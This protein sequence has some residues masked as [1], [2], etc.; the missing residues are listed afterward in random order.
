MR[1]SDLWGD[2]ELAPAIG[3]FLAEVDA[4]YPHR[5]MRSSG[6]IADSHHD[7]TSGH[8]PDAERLVVAADVDKDGVDM[9]QLVNAFIRH[10]AAHY[11]I[12]HRVIWSRSVGFAPSAFH[13]DNPHDDHGH[14]QVL[15]GAPAHLLTPYGIHTAVDHPARP[16]V[17]PGLRTLWY[18]RPPFVG[19]DVRYVQRFIGEAKCGHADGVFGP[20]TERGVRWY[21]GM[22][23]LRVDGIVGPVTWGSLLS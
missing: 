4:A 8:A 17:G 13:G 5:D 6:T 10:P 19:D 7:K 9:Q 2:W 14:F 23:G 18:T 16:N 15:H 20:H 21:Q 11:V 12:Y 22:R 1:H 3:V